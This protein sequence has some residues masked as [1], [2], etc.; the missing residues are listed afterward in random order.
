MIIF[1]FPVTIPLGRYLRDKLR[2]AI[3]V[4]DATKELSKKAY[5]EELLSMWLDYLNDPQVPKNQKLSLKQFIQQR[6]KQKILNSQSKAK[7][8]KKGKTL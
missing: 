2:D 3:G 4:N 8:K 6:D 1:G 7:L 5:Q